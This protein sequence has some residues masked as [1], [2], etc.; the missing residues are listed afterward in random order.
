MRGLIAATS[1]ALF[2][3]GLLISGM[4]DTNRVQGWLD[5]FGDWDPTLAFVLG[6]AI[7]PM[8]IAW[9][10]SEYR[11]APVAGGT[12]PLPLEQ[13]VTTDLAV[14]S[15]IFGAGWG[16]AGLCPG[17]SF[18]ALSFGGWEG[19]LFVGSMIG[20]MLLAVPARHFR[21]SMA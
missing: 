1:G 15:M 5:I 13:K 16:L 4:V 12:F 6:G 7:I 3:I 18:A 11:K 19:L 17:P 14:G 9:R 8:A 21:N 2:G 10:V 20:G